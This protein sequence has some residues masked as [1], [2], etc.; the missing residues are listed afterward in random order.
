MEKMEE[1]KN[2]R[3]EKMGYFLNFKMPGD[4]LT[5]NVRYSLLKLSEF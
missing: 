2:E 3:N 5:K 1:M 4:W